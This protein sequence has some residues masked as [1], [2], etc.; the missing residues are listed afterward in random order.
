[1]CA[2][3]GRR[4]ERV[5]VVAGRGWRWICKCCRTGSHCSFLPHT[6]T[7]PKAL[8]KVSWC[9]TKE[10]GVSTSSQSCPARGCSAHPPTRHAR[11]LAW[12]K[13]VRGTSVVKPSTHFKRGFWCLLEISYLITHHPVQCCPQWSS[14]CYGNIIS[15]APE[16]RFSAAI[17]TIHPAH[18]VKSS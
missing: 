6:L 16:G 3:W 1:M 17:D 4:G 10:V 2:G 15:Q 8:G 12:G 13:V 14:V 7:S 5:A 11:G 9:D 18:V